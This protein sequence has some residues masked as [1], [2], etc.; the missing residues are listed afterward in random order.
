MYVDKI[1]FKR[2]RSTNIQKMLYCDIN[3]QREKELVPQWAHKIYKCLVIYYLRFTFI[4]KKKKKTI[5]NLTM[6]DMCG[7]G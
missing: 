5:N 3:E 7:H 4:A 2:E 6:L 1:I